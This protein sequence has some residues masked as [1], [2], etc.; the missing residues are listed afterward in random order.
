MAKKNRLKPYLVES[1]INEK[2]HVINPDDAIVIVTTR[3]HSVNVNV[4]RYL[5]KRKTSSWSGKDRFQVVTAVNKETSKLVRNDDENVVWNYNSDKY[6]DDLK[7]LLKPNPP[8][9]V[10]PSRNSW[11]YSNDP[12]FDRRYKEYQQAYKLAEEVR[13]DNYKIIEKYKNEN[14]HLVKIPYVQHRTL[15]CNRI[16]PVNMPLKDLYL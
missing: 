13:R 16:Y 3:A 2:G 5:G 1:F 10:Y 12:E 11:S 4:G 14:Y 6:P 8:Q 15:Q 7:V 9:P